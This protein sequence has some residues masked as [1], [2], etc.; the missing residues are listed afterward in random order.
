MTDRRE[1]NGN[2][3]VQEKAKRRRIGLSLSAGP[4]RPT[5][6]LATTQT[7]V[8]PAILRCFQYHHC[9]PFALRVV[10]PPLWQS[11]AVCRFVY[12]VS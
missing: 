10:W 1:T 2:P 7:V 3:E 9:Q 11:I 6:E 4:H 12:A 5:R 8:A